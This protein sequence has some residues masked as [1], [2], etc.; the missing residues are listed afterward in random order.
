MHFIQKSGSA[1]QSWGSRVD[2][3]D[4]AFAFRM[5]LTRY[6]PHGWKFQD[7]DDARPRIK[8][9]AEDTIKDMNSSE[10]QIDEKQTSIFLG[11]P[12]V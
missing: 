5:N 9:F 1:G 12:I 11:V 8:S 7:A 6:D 3:I 10:T 4:W 2:D